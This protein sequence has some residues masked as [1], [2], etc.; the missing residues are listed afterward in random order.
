M[1]MMM[2]RKQ[3]RPTKWTRKLIA[4]NP[5]M[6]AIEMKHMPT[7]SQFAYCIFFFILHQANGATFFSFSITLMTL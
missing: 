3:K 6:N 4:K 5:L 1:M 7:H 2:M